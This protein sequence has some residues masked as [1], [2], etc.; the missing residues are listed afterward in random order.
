[1]LEF[2]AYTAISRRREW[3]SG[4]TKK[5]YSFHGGLNDLQRMHNLFLFR[6]QY[7]LIPKETHFPVVKSVAA[8][9]MHW[10]FLF[11]IS[12]GWSAGSGF[13]TSH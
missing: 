3:V 7:D 1:M 4:L 10:Q 2:G 5:G 11:A 8:Y 9:D 6:C 12:D 13:N